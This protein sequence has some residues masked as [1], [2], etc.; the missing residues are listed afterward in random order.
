LAAE[1]VESMRHS[2]AVVEHDHRLRAAAEHTPVEP[3]TLDVPLPR[4]WP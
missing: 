3:E 4:A 1:L 2:G